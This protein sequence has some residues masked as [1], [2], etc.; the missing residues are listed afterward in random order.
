MLHGRFAVIGRGQRQQ[1]SR[2]HGNYVDFEF[3]MYQGGIMFVPGPMEHLKSHALAFVAGALVL[4]ASNLYSR[5]LARQ[6]SEN[7]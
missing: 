3:L 5:Y 7:I 6:R 4:V 1:G 2:A